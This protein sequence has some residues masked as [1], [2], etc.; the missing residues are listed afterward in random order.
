MYESIL[1]IGAHCDD[2]ELGCG[3]FI[4]K[5]KREQLGEVHALVLSSMTR[6]GTPLLIPAMSAFTDLG[7]DSN[8]IEPAVSGNFPDRESV[9][10]SIR[11]MVEKIK[12]SLVLTHQQDGHP[13]H[14]LVRQETFNQSLPVGTSIASYSS[15][16]YLFNQPRNWFVEVEEEDIEAKLQALKR[17]HHVYANKDY[18]DEDLWRSWACVCGMNVPGKYADGFYLERMFS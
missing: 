14:H 7:V 16:P 5:V 6:D 17:Y 1:I 13:A 9:W 15:K 18:F 10:H 4:H 11:S 3:S 2:V 8:R 12:P